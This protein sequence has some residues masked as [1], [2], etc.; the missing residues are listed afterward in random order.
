MA[1]PRYA[2]LLL[3][4]PGPNGV[5]TVKGSFTLSDNCDREFSKI[6][7]SF[8][9]AAE[10]AQLKGATDYN[11]LPEAGRS[12]PDQ[13]FDSTKDTQEIQVHPSDPKKTT[14]IASNLDA[15]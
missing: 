8:G 15:A 12:L 4:I 5:I 14:F 6:S 2:Y 9:M 11:V 10:Y 13:A 7:D 1:V 3:K